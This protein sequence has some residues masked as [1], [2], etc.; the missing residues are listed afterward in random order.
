MSSSLSFPFRKLTPLCFAVPSQA[1]SWPE[2][3]LQ[4]T[5]PVDARPDPRALF[6]RVRWPRASV[7]ASVANSSSRSNERPR[8][9]AR[10]TS[11][12]SRASSTC[13]RCKQNSTRA[14]QTLS[15]I[16]TAST[17]CHDN[18]WPVLISS[19]VSRDAYCHVLLW[20]YDSSL[21]YFRLPIV[22]C[23]FSQIGNWQ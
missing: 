2:R 9:C 1:R 22:D 8:R 11:C 19:Y 12:E 14:R 7:H 3:R 20:A 17:W 23:Q 15:P 10:S 13:V 21:L 4:Q 18:L 16:D 6:D 5:I